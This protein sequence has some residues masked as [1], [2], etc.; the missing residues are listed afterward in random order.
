[1]WQWRG[2]ATAVA[3]PTSGLIS[4]PLP[5]KSLCAACMNTSDAQRVAFFRFSSV[6][7][8]L[9]PKLVAFRFNHV[10]LFGHSQRC[11]LSCFYSAAHS[12]GAR[13]A[14]VPRD[15]VT[16]H[17]QRRHRQSEGDGPSHTLLCV[18]HRA[19]SHRPSSR[20]FRHR[21]AH[22]RRGFSRV[23]SLTACVFSCAVLALFVFVGR[24]HHSLVSLQLFWIPF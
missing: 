21:Y 14:P 16:K 12:V 23:R 6:H 3:V 8:I 19:W 7:R 24:S 4:F 10:G 13:P 17:G 18:R 9:S 11:F 20:Q 5:I 2:C 1:M 22:W 15:P